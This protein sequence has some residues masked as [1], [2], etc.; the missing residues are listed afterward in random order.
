MKN[1]FQ[2]LHSPIG[3]NATFALGLYG[4]GGGFGLEEDR[5][6][7]QDVFIGIKKNN[8]ITCFPFFKAAS[9]KLSESFLQT[10]AKNQEEMIYAFKDSQITRDYQYGKDFFKAGPLQFEIACPVKSIPEPDTSSVELLKDALAPVL[11]SRLTVDNS[12]QEEEV[13]AFFALSPVLGKC[14]LS[15]KTGG[16]LKGITSKSG[17]GFAVINTQEIAITE[18][19]DFDLSSH[20]ARKIETRLT[21]A[22]MGGLFFR[23]P[24]GKKISI[25]IALGWYKPGRVTFGALECE[26]YYNRFFG[27]LTDVLEY[28]LKQSK[29]WWEEAQEC[30]RQLEATDL[31]EDKKFIIVHAARSYNAS[32]MLFNQGGSPL[33]VVNEGTFMMMNT[34]DLSVDHCFF[35]LKQNPWVVKNQLDLFYER[36]SYIDQCGLSFTHDCGTHHTFTP[37]GT[38]SYEIPG[39]DDCFSYMTQEQLCNWI[40]MAGM[41]YHH[42][43]DINWLKKKTAGVKMCLDSMINRTGGNK[44]GIMKI[45]SSRCEGGAEITTYDS[46]DKSLGQARDNLYI[47]M[48]CFSSYLSLEGMLLALNCKQEAD[49]A[50]QMAVQCS[51]AVIGQYNHTVGFV[52]AI[53]DGEDCSPIIPVIEPIIY[54]KYIGQEDSLTEN[55][56]FN[57][58]KEILKKHTSTI[59]KEGICLFPDQGFKLSANSDN[60]WMSKIFICCYTASE[61]LQ[62]PVLPESD[63]AHAQWWKCGCKD[64]PG[65]DQIISGNTAET[66]FHY[67]RGVTSTLWW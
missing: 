27:S 48:K 28:G 35:E 43:K 50:H 44:Y 14:F 23:V 11:I 60:S 36:Y 6:P 45:D 55:G 54:L 61:L 22:G 3:S 30:S 24:A 42:T 15:E 66:G 57:E 20:Y 33:W 21:V 37:V 49:T 39:L 2:A 32:T 38:S 25:N 59:L 31:N 19:A 10:E 13:E 46:L 5:V 7:A 40:L 63:Y 53:L 56:E 16:Q 62:I 52:P 29:K 64:N 51:K 8:E 65:I 41:Y 67:P 9:S 58:L 4:S 17:Y 18:V 1:D 26:Y 34:L 47:V 12:N